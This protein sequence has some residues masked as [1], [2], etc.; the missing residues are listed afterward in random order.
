MCKFACLEGHFE[1]KKGPMVGVRMALDTVTEADFSN[2][3]SALL[4]KMPFVES[5][6]G[7]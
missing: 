5:E 6:L 4:V 1:F 2:S 3:L 7:I